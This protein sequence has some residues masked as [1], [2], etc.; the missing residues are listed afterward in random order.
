MALSIYR[1]VNLL[2]VLEDRLAPRYLVHATHKTSWWLILFQLLVILVA[3]LGDLRS[4][5]G[6]SWIYGLAILQLVTA[7][8]LF[9]TVR[10][11]LKK[12]K[13]LATPKLLSEHNLPTLSVAIP[14]R[15]ETDGLEAC[16]QTLIA[17]DYPKLEILVL[18]DCSQN[19]R[20]PEIIRAYAH[21]GVRFI[22]GKVPP[23]HWLAKNYAYQQLAEAANGELLLFCGIDS[24]FQPG[25]L[26]GMVETLVAKNKKMISFIPRNHRPSLWNLE[27]TLIQP[28][29]YAWELSLPRRLVHRTPVLSTCWLI[30]ADLLKM[31]G[32]FAAEVSSISPESYF[33]RAAAKANDGYSFL[34]GDE[35]SDLNSDK[36]LDEQRATAIRTRYPQLHRRPELVGLWSV[37]E[38]FLTVAPFGLLLGSILADIWPLALLESLACS[39]LLVFYSRIVQLTYRRFLVRGIWL[40]PITTLYDIGLLNYSMWRYEFREVIWKDRN[41]C[42]PLMQVTPHL[43]TI[44]DSGKTH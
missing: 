10:R 37:L 18:D 44:P 21:D 5:P 20:T 27:A 1:L 16:L 41:I 2:R 26:R 29:R 14:A 38:V 3:G 43:P 33:A 35:V 40:L 30:T 32:G 17:S 13:P 42:V 25:S 7:I 6:L 22:A 23:K 39:L 19:K 28:A 4:I 11:N 36:S 24:R 34:R 12:T 15:N 8:I 9:T 31:T